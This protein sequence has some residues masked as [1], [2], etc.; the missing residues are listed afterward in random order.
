[1]ETH[2]G[3]TL[4]EL[5]VVMV[6]IGILATL[7]VTR[8]TGRKPFDE[9]G[10]AQELAAAA[11][12][13]Q[14]LA[15]S[16]RCNVLFELPDAAQYRLK[17]PDAFTAGTCAAN[18]NSDVVNPLTGQPPYVGTTPNGVTLASSDG[19]PASRTFDAQ[20]GV[21][22]AADLSIQVGDITVLLQSGGRV[23]VQ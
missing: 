9:F 19:F 12:Y 3:F 8:F 13:A 22:P 14:K 18:F 7:A 5:I 2:R 15:V 23:I 21:S 11:R 16:T 6:V 1:M 4:I 20:G 10:Y 17:R